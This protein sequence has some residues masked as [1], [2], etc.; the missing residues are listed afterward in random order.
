MNEEPGV[1]F[2]LDEKN[3]AKNSIYKPP[4]SGEPKAQKATIG[5]KFA[6]GVRFL[7]PLG[8]MLIGK[9]RWQRIVF[10]CKHPIAY[11]R[12]FGFKLYRRIKGIFIKARMVPCIPRV[13]KDKEEL[14]NL[15]PEVNNGKKASSCK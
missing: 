9:T 11:S 8:F 6:Q 7:D 15:Y 12:R 10:R 4:E 13:G 1:R 3:Q 2:L 5:F 14:L